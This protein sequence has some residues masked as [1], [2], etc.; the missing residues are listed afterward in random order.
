MNRL[1]VVGQPISHS[2][3]PPMQTA[4]LRELGLDGEWSYEAIELSPEG[5][6]AGVGELRERGYV[7][8]NV[9]VPHK[10]AALTLADDASAAARAIG[11]ANTLTFSGEGIRADNTDA[12][13]LLAAL[14]ADLEGRRTLVLGAGGAARAAAWA[15]AGAGAVVEVHNRTR[16]RAAELA[17]ELGVETLAEPEPGATLPLAGFDLL[18]NATS[19]GLATGD[20]AAGQVGDDLKK[21][22]LTAD[23][24][25]DRMVVVDLVYGAAPT[26]LVS[27]AIA[28]GATVVDGLEILVRQGAESLRI[29]TGSEPPLEA[30]RAAIQSEQR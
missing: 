30:M 18:V 7:G 24:F 25:S 15:L 3:S 22:G 20:S 12:P 14:P 10:L 4:A 2:L 27:A 8:V 16:L 11:A 28:A 5:F 19:V 6:D 13:G 29:W 23:E 9:T 26:E 17:A 21:L 1:A